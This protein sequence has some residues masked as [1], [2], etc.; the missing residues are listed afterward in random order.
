MAKKTK[1]KKAAIYV[2]VSTKKQS[3]RDYSSLEVQENRCKAW[4]DYQNKKGD[5]VYEV[6]DTYKDVKSGKDL[7]RPGIER[8]K[9]DAQNQKFDVVVIQKLDRISRSISDFSNLY[10]MLKDND[11]DIVINDNNIDTSTTSGEMMQKL[12]MLFAEFERN[13]MS[14]RMKTKREETA[15]A[16]LWQGGKPPLGY[17]PVRKVLQIDKNEEELVKEIFSRY[18]K[19]KSTPRVAKSLNKDGYTTKSWITQKGKSKGGKEF[20]DG[21]V[22][23]ILKSKVYLGKIEYKDEVFDGQHEP[24]VEQSTYD[25]VQQIMKGNRVKPKKYNKGS[26]PAVLKNIAEC[27]FCTRPLTTS[28]TKKGEK[29]YYY[30]KC[31]KKNRQGNTEDHAPKP[32]SVPTLDEFVF[33]TFKILLKEPELM[34]ALKKRAE[35]EEES[36]ID[37]LTKKIDRLHQEIKSLSQ[38]ISQTKNLLTDGPGERARKLLLDEL[39]SLALKKEEREN[40]VEIAKEEKRKLTE[41]D[42]KNSDTY[43]KLLKHVIHKWEHSMTEEKSDLT[44]TLVRNVISNVDRDSTGTVEIE[45]I[46]DK[47]LNADWKEIYNNDPED[48]E[49]RTVGLAQS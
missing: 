22:R 2:R 40:E 6:H 21:V 1:K 35:F 19:L 5:Q 20:T 3:E 43:K 47:K 24:I 16:G 48:V 23:R 31:A 15:K 30:Y 17:D 12:L 4:V 9:K 41:Q 29:K 36:Q 14:D 8:L 28:S 46:A 49:V 42:P 7:N 27:G 11:I 39:D 26:T 37:K 10:D 45:Y 38:K 34:N 25:Q 18:I 44:Q 33:R 32:L 13:I